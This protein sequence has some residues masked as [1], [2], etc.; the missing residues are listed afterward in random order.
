MIWIYTV[1][2][3]LLLQLTSVDGWNILISADVNSKLV[4][5]NGSSYLLE[6]SSKLKHLGAI[7]ISL[8][9]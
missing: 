1:I 5:N 3:M 8:I 7:L 9:F 6:I 2:Q 4:K